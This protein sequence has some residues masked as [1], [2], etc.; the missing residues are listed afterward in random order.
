MPTIPHRFSLAAFRKYE[1][2]IAQIAVKFP[3]A[4]TINPSSMGLSGETVRGRLRDAITSCL[5]NRWQP[6]TVA[7][8]ALL[9]ADASGLV[10]SLR[11]DG[12]VIVGTKETIRAP[13]PISLDSIVESDAIYDAT[14][15][16][17][18]E[19]IELLCDLAAAKQLKN[20]VKLSLADDYAVDLQNR[21]DI[22]LEHKPDQNVYLLS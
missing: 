17:K 19:Q 18:P 16:M 13:K 3:Q 6:T 14:S 22:V 8:A 7:Y 12:L 20:K 11:P 21:F 4:V 15:W 10:V 9:H 2:V 1:P 5:S